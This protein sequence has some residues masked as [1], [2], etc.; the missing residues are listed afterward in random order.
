MKSGSL[1]P[2]PAFQR[3]AGVD[4]AGRGPLAGP[5]SVAAVILDPQRPIVGLDDSKKLSEA[6]R[7]ALFPI[8]IERA[9]AWR[10]EFVEP[11]EIDAHCRPDEHGAAL[12]RNAATRLNLSARAYHRVLRVARSI[13][14]LA[15]SE[16]VLSTHIAE[17]IQYRRLTKD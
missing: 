11:R 4:E 2:A 3:V 14:D 1:F 10:V 16:A 9:L 17:A 15:G 8:I 13:A 6:R 12:L 5:V 7:E